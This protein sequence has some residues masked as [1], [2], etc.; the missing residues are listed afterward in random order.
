[1]NEKVIEDPHSD[2]V[3]ENYFDAHEVAKLDPEYKFAGRCFNTGQIIAI[4]GK[5]SRDNFNDFVEWS[6]PPKVKYP[7][8][9]SCGEQGLLNYILAKKQQA[10]HVSV[11]YTKFMRWARSEKCQEFQLP[12]IENKA[13][14]PFIIH[15][16]GF[17][18]PHML[19]KM[20]RFDIL[21]FYNDFYCSKL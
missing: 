12:I 20:K 17:K 18:T 15:W 19:K 2:Y 8:I 5:I 7:R 9:F 6:E 21:N 16:A 3:K 11:R 10:G 1:M 4:S 14:Y 13:G